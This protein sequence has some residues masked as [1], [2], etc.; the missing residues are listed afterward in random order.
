MYMYIQVEL[1]VLVPSIGGRENHSIAVDGEEC[2][3][4]LQIELD[5]AAISQ[6]VLWAERGTC[7]YKQ[8]KV[9]RY[10]DTSRL[11]L[12]GIGIQAG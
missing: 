3:G 8:V 5:V 10:R 2:V 4:G 7:I 1:T 9:R 11:K 6:L 12:G